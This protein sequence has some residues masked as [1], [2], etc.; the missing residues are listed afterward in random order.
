MWSNGSDDHQGRCSVNTPNLDRVQRYLLL[1]ASELPEGAAMM[2]EDPRGAY[3]D[4]FD[5]RAAYAKDLA[6]AVEAA[7]ED[8]RRRT[9]DALKKAMNV[10]MRKAA[11]F[12]RDSLAN[13]RCLD[14]AYGYE[15]AIALIEAM[16]SQPAYPDPKP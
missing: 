5:V 1:T 3:A 15:N 4:D 7:R 10:A 13:N 14:Q 9:V 11:K 12:A 16:S 8:E 6:E 2:V